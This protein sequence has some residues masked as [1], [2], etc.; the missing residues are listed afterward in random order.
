MPR[1]K[2]LGPLI[3]TVPSIVAAP[4]LYGQATV[5]NDHP[6]FREG[7]P[8]RRIM[9]WIGSNDG[10]LHAFDFDTGDEIVALVPPQVLAAQ[11]PLYQNFLAADRKGTGQPVGFENIYGVAGSLRFGDVFFP[12]SLR[13]AGAPSAS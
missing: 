1:D 4:V 10:M 7:V 5:A 3:N 11:V 2:R 6:G 8:Q 9:I 12:G 13:D